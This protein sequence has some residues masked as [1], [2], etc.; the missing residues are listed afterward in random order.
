MSCYGSSRRTRSPISAPGGSNE[1]VL[2]RLTTRVSLRCS[3]KLEQEHEAR[4]CAIILQNTWSR[5][6]VTTILFLA[7]RLRLHN[8]EGADRDHGRVTGTEVM[9]RFAWR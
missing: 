4:E 9:E 5:L 2:V 8:T 6:T 1:V 3:N 7:P